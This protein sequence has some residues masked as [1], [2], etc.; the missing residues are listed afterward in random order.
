MRAAPQ[1]GHI[2]AALERTL[3]EALASALV[4]SHAD[5]KTHF[6]A[7]VVQNY[8]AISARVGV[9]FTSRTQTY[10]ARG[11]T[12]NIGEFPGKFLTGIT[13][14]ISSNA[15]FEGELS[16]G[17]IRSCTQRISGGHN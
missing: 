9:G 11:S 7:N 5:T 16:K 12:R 3:V 15:C 1:T 2:P 14:S 8:C 4:H 10:L 13:R 6:M 17:S